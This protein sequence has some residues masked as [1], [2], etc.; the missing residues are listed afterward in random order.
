MQTVLVLMILAFMGCSS[1]QKMA[2]RS[3]TPVMVEGADKFSHERNWELFREAMPGNLKFYEVLYL[4]DTDNLELLGAVVK[5]YAAYS[6]GVEETLALGDRLDGFDDSYHTQNA[7]ELYTRSLD[8][9][10]DY[11]HKKGLKRSDLLN[12]G[13]GE[14]KKKLSKAFDREDYKVILFTAQS[15]VS[16]IKLQTQNPILNSHLPRAKVVFDWVC[17][18]ERNIENG[19]CDLYFAEYAAALTPESS[20]QLY[21][22]AIKKRPLSLL[23]RVSYIQHILMQ[24]K[25]LSAYEVEAKTLK[26]E[27][28][29]W[30]NLNRDTLDDNSDYKA[31]EQLNLFNAIAEKRFQFIEKNKKK[32]FEG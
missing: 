21:Q 15:W 30:R 19:V 11:M 29:R 13:D 8:Y 1:V 28:Q 22:A 10:L 7:I 24:E 26:E 16:L 27:F 32:I 20:K 17:G 23:V 18:E 6:F 9:G 14:L 2:M 3:A 4:Q 25:N 5:G 12:M 31:E